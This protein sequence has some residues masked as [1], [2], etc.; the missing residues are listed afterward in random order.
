[1]FINHIIALIFCFLTTFIK[2]SPI[3][4]PIE[5]SDFEI[6]PELDY[7]VETQ[8]DEY[9]INNYYSLIDIFNGDE[10]MIYKRAN[11]TGGLQLDND[12]LSRTINTILLS[13]N[14]SGVIWSL[15]DAVANYPSRIDYIGNLTSTLLKGRNITIDVG[16][17]LS[18]DTT[19]AV[20]AR[21]VNLTAALDAVVAS[22]LVDSLLDGLL[23]DQAFRP[24]LV[25]I[26]DRVVWSQRDTLLYIFGSLLQKRGFLEEDEIVNILKRADVATNGT[27][28]TFVTNIIATVLGSG[29]FGQVAGDLLNSLNDTGIAVYVVKRFLSNDAYL[30]MTARLATDLMSA[31][32]IHIS[33]ESLNITNVLN[34]ALSDPTKITLI[35]GS[36]LSGDSSLITNY[37]GRYSGAIQD[38]LARLESK[39]LFAELN[40]YIW[41]SPSATTS[42]TLAPSATS[43]ANRNSAATTTGGSS[44][45]SVSVSTRVADANSNQS[46]SSSANKIDTNYKIQALVL[47]PTAILSMLLII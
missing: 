18:G 27:L 40:S 11:N 31:G 2:S 46:K 33:F 6:I 22:G 12:Q 29:I 10:E 28:N 17:L 32:A 23:L 7:F 26:V 44:T 39:G 25:D 13:V 15:L 34:N 16:E 14:S 35:V 36:L 38:I 19:N 37:F 8:F 5:G 47:I 30:N 21:S 42:I 9:E 41:G 3:T 43:N 45:G 24:R 4:S 20:W 1:M